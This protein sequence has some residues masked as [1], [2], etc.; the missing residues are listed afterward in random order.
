M[1]T[2]IINP[3]WQLTE[4]CCM[5]KITIPTLPSQA[6]MATQYLRD[7][8]LDADFIDYWTEKELSKAELAKYDV[9]VVWAAITGIDDIAH[10]LLAAKSY[11]KITVLVVNELFADLITD[12]LKEYLF[13]DYG[14]DHN[15][16]E[17]SLSILIKSLENKTSI[18]L[19]SGVATKDKHYGLMP[20]AKDATHLKSCANILKTL[21]LSKY[22]RAYITTGKG[23][24][25]NCSFCSWRHTGARK[26]DVGDII[27]EIKAVAPHIHEGTLIDAD[28]P[29][30]PIW[31]AEFCDKL[32]QEHLNFKWLSTSRADQCKPELLRKMKAAGCYQLCIGVETLSE[33]GLVLS[34]KGITKEQVKA[35]IHNCRQAGI[36]PYTTLMVGFPWDSNETLRETEEFVKNNK[37]NVGVSL[38]IPIKGTPLYE[39]FK[40]KG[41][42]KKELQYSDYKNWDTWTSEARCETL[43]LN[44]KELKAWQTRF[45]RAELNTATILRALHRGIKIVHFEK[46]YRI[47]FKGE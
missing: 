10:I 18:P 42:L 17:I 28:L 22:T 29:S 11:R 15:E 19:C 27:A 37:L 21:P 4:E 44:K 14:I 47:L 3:K 41:L 9:I 31:L 8:G 13:I 32:A 40:E 1:K 25:Y 6:I 23:C 38:V 34:K 46:A 7:N 43:F 12:I 5:G 36:N 2:L 16:R 20:I 39:E 33:K 24:P 45:R 30:N 35:K 26:R